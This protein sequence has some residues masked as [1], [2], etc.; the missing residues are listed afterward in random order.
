M[1]FNKENKMLSFK[2]N[3]LAITITNGD[4]VTRHMLLI[5]KMSKKYYIL[6][7]EFKD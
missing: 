6:L 2:P 1:P 5:T 7:G 4:G 3:I